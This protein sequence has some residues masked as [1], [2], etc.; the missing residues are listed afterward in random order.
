MWDSLV[1]GFFFI[2]TM[3]DTHCTY[4]ASW[5]KKPYNIFLVLPGSII[6][7]CLLWAWANQSYESMIMTNANGN[8]VG[9]QSGTICGNWVSIENRTNIVTHDQRFKTLKTSRATSTLLF[10][11]FTLLWCFLLRL[12]DFVLDQVF[13]ISWHCYGRENATPKKWYYIINI[14]N[15][16]SFLQ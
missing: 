5:S 10:F 7:C 3:V 12:M 8:Y 16:T 6:I 13:F 4:T 9:E 1:S 11:F 2:A 15:V 14:S